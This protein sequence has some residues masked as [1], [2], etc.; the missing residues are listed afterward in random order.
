MVDVRKMSDSQLVSRAIRLDIEEK[1]S[2]KQLDETKTELQARGLAVLEEHN[3]KFVR[4]YSTSGNVSVLDAQTLDVLNAEKIRELLLEGVFESK[5]EVTI[6]KKKYKFD[7]KLE[8]MLKAVF[9]GDFTFEY[10]LEEF[11]ETEMKVK[12]ASKKRLLL[13]KLV[14]DYKKDK[15]TLVSALGYESED[16]APDFDVELYYIYK[17]KNGELI[18]A[19]LPEEGLDE[20]ISQLRNCMIV[21][22][23][24][25]ITIDYDKN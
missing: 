14:G 10:T 11:I 15:Q 4:F 1:K 5:V 25:S 12:D 8:Q 9:T 6:Q 23:K 2:K 22:S 17:I 16:A 18:K 3:T 20:T 21:D 7:S 19:F 13:K 24:T